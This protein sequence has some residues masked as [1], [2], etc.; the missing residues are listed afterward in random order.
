MTTQ[1]EANLADAEVS[2]E[3]EDER[4][5]SLVRTA[6]VGKDAEDFLA[7]SVG[8]FVIGSAHQDQVA[9]QEKLTGVSPMSLFGRRKIAKLQM[10]HRAIELGISWLL[11][12]IR[13]GK[14]AERQLTEP[15]E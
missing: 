2:V 3:F 15:T 5:E 6:V 14:M 11:D 1:L 7:S 10:E 9:I 13:I 4:E 8:Q 12:A